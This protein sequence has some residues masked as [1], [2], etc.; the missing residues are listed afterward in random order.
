MVMFSQEIQMETSLYG[1]KVIQQNQCECW[2]AALHDSSLIRIL[3][4][5]VGLILPLADILNFWQLS[6]RGQFWNKIIKSVD[7]LNTKSSPI[8]CQ[9]LLQVVIKRHIK[10]LF[11]KISWGIKEGA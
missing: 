6:E 8:L 11:K 4:E 9:K 1:E 2:L 5:F 10:T 3:S 7:K